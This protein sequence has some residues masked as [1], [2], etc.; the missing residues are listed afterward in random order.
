[1]FS[2]ENQTLGM[3]GVGADTLVKEGLDI[4]RLGLKGLGQGGE[5]RSR[6]RAG[7]ANA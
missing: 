3:S 5:I 4:V 2:A 1:V 7:S 6:S